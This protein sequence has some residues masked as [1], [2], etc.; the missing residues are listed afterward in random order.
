MGLVS[1]DSGNS[2][3]QNY[4]KNPAVNFNFMLRV[5]GIFDLPCKSVHAFQKENEYEIIQEGGLND[6]VHMRRKPV[7]KPFTFQVERYVGVDL[8]DPLAN[9]TDLTLPVILMVNRYLAYGDFHPVRCYVFTGCTVMAKEY[10]ALDAEKSGLM[11]ETTTIAYQEMFCID[12]PVSSFL[13][14]EPWGFDGKKKEGNGMQSAKRNDMEQSKKEMQEQSKKWNIGKKAEN[15]SAVYNEKE[16]D[17]K[18]MESNAKKWEIGKKT[19]NQSAVHN[20]QELSKKQMEQ[21]ARK[22]P[23]KRSAADVAAFLSKQ[24]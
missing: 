21:K 14:Q 9:G 17:K 6:Y 16:L 15:R 22:W 7:S 12:N 3:V 13:S 20:K 24:I 19:Q 1:A 11:I 4:G 10:G 5:E 18:Q 23:K 8:L 2:I